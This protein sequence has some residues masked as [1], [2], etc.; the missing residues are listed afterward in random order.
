MVPP[1][2]MHALGSLLSKVGYVLWVFISNGSPFY[3][4]VYTAYPIL[5]KTCRLFVHFLST[6]VLLLIKRW[7]GNGCHQL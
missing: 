4:L 1:K 5:C 3:H 2:H 6:G 7:Y